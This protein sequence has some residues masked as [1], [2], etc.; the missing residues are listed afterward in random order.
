MPFPMVSK[1]QFAEAGH[2]PRVSPTLSLQPGPDRHRGRKVRREVGAADAV[3][4]GDEDVLVVHQPHVHDPGSLSLTCRMLRVKAA[5][6]W[7]MG[8]NLLSSHRL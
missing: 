2:K 5:Y 1:E 6:A 3:G 4:V 8:T 7:I